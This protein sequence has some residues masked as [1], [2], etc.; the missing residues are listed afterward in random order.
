M[1]GEYLEEETSLLSLKKLNYKLLK[2][3][4]LV[5]L[6]EETFRFFTA[7]HDRRTQVQSAAKAALPEEAN[8]S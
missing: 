8:A 2:C 4:Q 3:E 5:R 7:I 1:E 6:A